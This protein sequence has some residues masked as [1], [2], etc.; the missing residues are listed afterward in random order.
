MAKAATLSTVGEETDTTVDKDAPFG[1]KADGTPRKRKASNT[2][3]RENK[4]IHVL[5]QVVDSDGKSIPGAKLN[6]L[7]AGKDPNKVIE[8]MDQHP[9]VARTTVKL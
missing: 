2:G 8:A 9:G 5:F 1:R 3:K 4:P 6:V 7:Y